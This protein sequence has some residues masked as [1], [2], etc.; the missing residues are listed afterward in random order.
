MNWLEVLDGGPLTT[1]QDAGRSGFGHLGVPPSG[2][3]DGPAAR[4]ANRLVGNAEGEALLET[5][6]RGPTLQLT[7]AS[8]NIV[9]AVTGAPAPLQIEGRSVDHLMPTLLRPGQTLRIGTVSAGVRS[10]VAFRGGL[11]VDPVLGS[12]S[13]DLLSGLG[14]APLRTG[15]RLPVGTASHP[16]PEADV[17]AVGAVAGI[18]PDPV[19]GIRPGPS[20]GWFDPSALAAL[21]SAR[22]TVSPTSSRVGLRLDG[23]ELMRRTDRELPPEG[24]V[25]GAL[26]VPP[27]GQPVLLLADHP[28]TGGYPVIA[29]VADRDLT[30]AA[31]AAPGTSIRF[32][33]LSSPAMPDPPR[34]SP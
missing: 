33:L 22:W 12:R 19:V 8:E 16:V 21:T 9:I 27:D 24:M 17:S 11:L 32:R 4:L 28:T 30:L 31:Q 1:V 18:D 14:P 20:D 10:Y 25:T 3:L 7:S 6:G 34:T 2:W 13:T 15:D 23:P 29:V 26:Q 5:T